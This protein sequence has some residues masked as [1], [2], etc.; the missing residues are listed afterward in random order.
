MVKK[1]NNLISSD[2]KVQINDVLLDVLMIKNPKINIYP[3]WFHRNIELFVK[4]NN[5]ISFKICLYFEQQIS[6][7]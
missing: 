1:Y 2:Q 3:K 7:L 4:E 5:K 6:I